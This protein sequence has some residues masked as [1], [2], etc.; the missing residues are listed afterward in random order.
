M[1]LWGRAPA[2]GPLGEGG[3]S[4]TRSSTP[5]RG[6]S[7]T[8]CPWGPRGARLVSRV[9]RARCSVSAGSGPSPPSAQ[10]CSEERGQGSGR[11]KAAPERPGPGLPRNVLSER[12]RRKRISVSCE[13]LRALLPRF[14]GRREDMASV[15]EMSVQFLRLVGTLLPGQEQHTVFASSKEP[16]HKWQKDVTQLAMLGPA[17]AVAPDCGL[18]ACGLTMPQAPPN[19]ATAGV[20]EAPL[21]VAEVLDGPPALPEPCSLLSQPPGP[22]PSKVLRPPPP[23]PAHSW[24]PS[25]PL[26]SEEAQSCLCQA[27]EPPAEGAN[28]IMTLDPRPAAGCDVEDGMSFLLNASPDWWLGSLEGR[29]ASVPSR[30]TARSSLLDRAEPSF[31]TDPEPGS[32]ELLGGPL[33]PW[34]SDVGCPSLALREEVDSIF[35]DFFPF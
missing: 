19:C 22:S 23:W 27:G 12:E 32:Q 25:S 20:G 28:S 10:G 2:A 31:L 6:P 16:W 24:Q 17:A 30:S 34:G 5:P 8:S 14:D 1:T 18:E 4:R 33:E 13:R 11:V 35:P 21:G 15:L 26:V 7:E 3:P 29:G 9:D